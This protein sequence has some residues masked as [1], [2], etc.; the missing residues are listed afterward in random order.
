MKHVCFLV[1]LIL[2]LVVLLSS[3]AMLVRGVVLGKQFDY[4]FASNPEIRFF[5]SG[6]FVMIDVM[7]VSRP[8]PPGFSYQTGMIKF[9]GV[10]IWW[11]DEHADRRQ[12]SPITR[13][14][15]EF[16]V[17]LYWP[18]AL[19]LVLPVRWTSVRL[20]RRRRGHGFPVVSSSRGR[21]DGER[22]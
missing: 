7:K 3:L 12:T 6:D 19:S 2:S 11:I 20:R 5:A 10:M 8:W 18:L 14:H 1:A 9:G 15:N 17:T 21:L 22:E 13:R 16:G 4:T